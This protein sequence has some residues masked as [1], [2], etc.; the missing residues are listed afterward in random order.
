MKSFLLIFGLLILTACGGEKKATE[1]SEECK[2]LTTVYSAWQSFNSCSGKM[3]NASMEVRR[4]VTLKCTDDWKKTHQSVAPEML[5]K[6]PYF[7]YL[8]VS[9]YQKTPEIPEVKEKF[10][11]CTGDTTITVPYNDKGEIDELLHDKRRNEVFTTTNRCY[12]EVA[13][14]SYH[15][16]KTQFQCS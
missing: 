5:A 16:Y 13:D 10:E 7:E 15:K 2:T 12:K 6:F 1:A 4:D 11:S 8:Y 3:I 14:E 9:S